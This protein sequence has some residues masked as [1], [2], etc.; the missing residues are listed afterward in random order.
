MIGDLWVGIQPD[1]KQAAPDSLHPCRQLRPA[2][3]PTAILGTEG[4]WAPD[5]SPDTEDEQEVL[6][7][8]RDER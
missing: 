2:T 1:P 8:L 6:R 3:T 7:I 5:F 4:N